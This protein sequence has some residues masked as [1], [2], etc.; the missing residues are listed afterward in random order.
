MKINL[1]FS[2]GLAAEI[3]QARLTREV[4]EGTTTATLLAQLQDEF[5]AA[6]D[7]LGRAVCMQQGFHVESETPL[8]DGQELA[9]LL[10]IAGGQ[11]ARSPS[12][13]HGDF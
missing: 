9:L 12:F 2:S 13:T 7:L 10:P 4:A 8:Q 5:P 1:R 3:G 11:P 6:G